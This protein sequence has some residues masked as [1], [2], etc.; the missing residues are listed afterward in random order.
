MLASNH[1]YIKR[2]REK[3]KFACVHDDDILKELLLFAVTSLSSNSV[4]LAVQQPSF[5]TNSSHLTSFFI[6]WISTVTCYIKPVALHIPNSQLLT[7]TWCLIFFVCLFPCQF[8]FLVVNEL[9]IPEMNTKD[10][11][12]SIHSFN[13]YDL[14]FILVQI[15]YLCYLNIGFLWFLYLIFYALWKEFADLVIHF[16]YFAAW[17]RGWSLDT[18]MII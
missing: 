14:L 17:F 3:N 15:E 13:L 10:S 9:L 1:N 18:H 5:K 12:H 6:Q 8:Q 2:R 16:G 7:T 4:S 11:F